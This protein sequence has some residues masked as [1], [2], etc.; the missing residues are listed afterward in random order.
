MSKAS[1]ALMLLVVLLALDVQSVSAGIPPGRYAIGDSVM[2]GAREELTARGIRVNASVSRQF[3]DAVPL[4]RQLKD[5]GRLRRKIIIHLGNNGI[6][7][8]AADCDRISQI[9]GANRTVYLVNLKIPRSYRRV[10]NERLAACA[11]RRAN[12][13]L[14]DWF[15]YSRQHP[16]WF[17]ADGFHLT[18]TGQTK[19][20]SIIATRTA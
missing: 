20:A 12:T 15:N 17:A 3:R 5:A 9:A 16:S 8:E 7:I 10:Q 6:I 2:L 1:R 4:V 14:I 18:A 19:F 13:V 11:Q